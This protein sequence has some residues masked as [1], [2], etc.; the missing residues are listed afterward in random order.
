MTLMTT[1]VLG[2]GEVWDIGKGEYPGDKDIPI[3]A[4]TCSQE[5]ADGLKKSKKKKK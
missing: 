2:K 4:L 3:N 1:I 5:I